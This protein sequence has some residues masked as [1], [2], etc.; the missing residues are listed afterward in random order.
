[1][2]RNL[3]LLVTTLAVLGLLFV[4]YL[5]LVGEPL[6]QPRRE[7]GALDAL[8]ARP[9]GEPSLRVAQRLEVPPGEGVEFTVY[10]EH[11]GRPKQHFECVEW[12]PVPG[13]N[14]EVEV[15][16]LKLAQWL[17][18]GMHVVISAARGRIHV[19]HLD[20]AQGK[21]R[22]GRLDGNVR[23]VLDRARQ[24]QRPPLSERPE[25][26]VTVVLE[27]LDFNLETGALAS[28]GPVDVQSSDFQLR[29]SGLGLVWNQVENMLASFRL[30]QGEYLVLFG[31]NGLFRAE[32]ARTAPDSAPATATRPTEPPA[33]RVGYECVLRGEVLAEQFQGDQPVGGLVADEVRLLFDLKAAS[34]SLSRR[35][36]SQ[37]ATLPAF[38]TT[39][40]APAEPA[41]PAVRECLLV[42]WD[43]PL[44]LVPTGVAVDAEQ[45]RR[46]FAAR[47]TPLRLARKD[48]IVECAGVEYHDETEQVWVYPQPGVPIQLAMGTRLNASA[49]TVYIDNRARIVKLLGNVELTAAGQQ[50]GAPAR[51]MRCSLWSELHLT[52]S[53]QAATQPEEASGGDPLAGSELES[54]SFVGDARID[55][56]DQV[57]SA[58]RVDVTFDPTLTDQPLEKRLRTAKS[59]GNVRLEQRDEGLRCAQLELSFALDPQGRAYPQQMDALGEVFIQRRGAWLR[60]ERVHA[61]LAPPPAGAGPDAPQFVLR[62]LDIIENAELRDTSNQIRA[63]GRQISAEFADINRLVRGTVVGTAERPAL[64]QRTPYTIRGA[65]VELSSEAQSLLVEGPSR[66]RFRAQRSLQ[67]VQRSQALPVD[68]T[69]TRRLFIDGL[70]NGVYFEGEVRARSGDE[71]LSAEKLT[72]LLEDAAPPPPGEP[73]TARWL[74]AFGQVTAAEIVPSA[75]EG[76]QK[77]VHQAHA[78][79]AGVGLAKQPREWLDV[80]SGERAALRKEP[81]RLIADEALVESESFEPPDPQPIVHMSISAPRVEIDLLRREII[82]TGETTLLA[83]SRR[84]AEGGQPDDESFGVPSGLITRGPSQTA[85]RCERGMTYALGSVSTPRRDSVLFDGAVRFVHRAGREMVNLEEMLPQVQTNPE[86]ITNLKSRNTGLSCDRL[87]CGFL[88]DSGAGGEVAAMTGRRAMQLAWL[89]AS[90]NAELRDRQ[91][92][93]IRT[94]RAQQLDFDREQRQVG[95]TGSAQA[96]ARIY[97]EDPETGE[98]K[99]MAG[100]SFRIDLNTNTVRSGP[101][102]GELGEQ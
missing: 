84:L 59:L 17:P 72:L 21:P 52:Q 31:G 44:T 86:L 61:A 73:R 33:E 71:Q 41:A 91:G 38:A 100:E 80:R 9:A 65:Q 25:D 15:T 13:T 3:L 46:H 30:E 45:P 28:S 68:I 58:D 92:S 82:S 88:V 101:T 20:R 96:A 47:G 2:R 35:P 22:S 39:A 32:M 36:A 69:A 42:Q 53:Q 63:R 98:S 4:G 90:G 95:I 55:L 11:T 85:M 34:E 78:G 81:I 7:R 76:S 14:D 19:D 24:R 62:T 74:R 48:S 77:L 37:P 43:G 87:E 66:L 26:A 29:G 70:R 64:V 97:E 50:P 75:L 18:S 99:V 67:G 23:I 40:S 6:F 5:F 1:M 12:A 49:D 8:P 51:H 54:A 94:V 57:L 83:T 79:L 27:H 16:N 56:G 60:G 93:K 89:I 10:E 102:R